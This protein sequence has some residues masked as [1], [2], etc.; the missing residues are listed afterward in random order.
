MRKVQWILLLMVVI[1]CTG[2]VQKRGAIIYSF[3][4]QYIDAWYNQRDLFKKYN[5]KAT[6]F[7]NRPQLLD[8]DKINKLRQLMQ[9]GHEIGCHGLNHKNVVDYKDS[10][11][12]LLATEIIPAINDL[13]NMGFK[14]QSYAY[15]YGKSI[16]KIDSVLCNYFKYLRKATW[17]INDTTIDTYDDIFVNS[18]SQHV[19][20]SMGID[21]NYRI[22]LDN[23]ETGL[24]RA[25]NKNEVLVLHDHNIDTIAGSYVINPAFLES[26]FK[27][28]KKYNIESITVSGLEKYFSSQ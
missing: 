12:V 15:P 3:D 7:I 22:S 1:S 9:D 6:F 23:F 13:N 27:L 21:S 28:C 17:N 10:I 18:A 26:T 16:P 20:N 25:I 11:D 24:L 2:E 5:I 19:M 8:S 4:A 14:I